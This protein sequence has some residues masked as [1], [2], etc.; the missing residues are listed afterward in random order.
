MMKLVN[1]RRYFP[2]LLFIIVPLAGLTAEGKEQ[3][4][5]QAVGTS[6]AT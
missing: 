5:R 6:D 4:A 3:A 2:A 1:I